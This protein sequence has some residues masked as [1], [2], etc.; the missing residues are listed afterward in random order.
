M[1]QATDGA[2]TSTATLNYEAWAAHLLLVTVAD[3]S[4][5]NVTGNVTVTVGNVNDPPVLIVTPLSL[6]ENSPVGTRVNGSITAYVAWLCPMLPLS[7][8]YPLRVVGM[9][10]TPRA[11]C[12][13][14]DGPALGSASQCRCCG[15]Q[16]LLREWRRATPLSCMPVPVFGC[17]FDEDEAFLASQGFS[18]RLRF[19]VSRASGGNDTLAVDAVTGVLTSL[20]PLDFEAGSMETVVFTVA[21]QA[22]NVTSA[23][24]VSVVDANDAPVFVCAPAAAPACYAYTVPENSAMSTLLSGPSVLVS[25]QDA[26]TGDTLVLF[27]R[28]VGAAGAGGDLVNVHPAGS[29][30][31]VAGAIDFETTPA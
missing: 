13:P 7:R 19:S 22:G 29:R 23:V 10:S 18:S 20:A 4:G 31:F 14:E 21:D 27:V 12:A 24:N 2:V 8:C 30:P 26:G 5:L 9:G 17:R 16:P 28:S 15:V 3:P 6:V 11:P 1:R 25:D